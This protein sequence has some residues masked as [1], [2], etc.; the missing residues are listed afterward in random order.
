MLETR[1]LNKLGIGDDKD[2]HEARR[3][4][5]L[6]KRLRISNLITA[7]KDHHLLDCSRQTAF[8]W[9]EWPMFG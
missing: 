3:Y 9:H 4:L 2:P 7:R 5:G 8:R 6:I 1:G